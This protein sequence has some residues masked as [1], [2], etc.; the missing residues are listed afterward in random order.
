MV[1]HV[2][3]LLQDLTKEAARDFPLPSL[4]SDVISVELAYVALET[5]VWLH[6]DPLS[7][8]VPS[9]VSVYMYMCMREEEVSNYVC[10]RQPLLL[11]VL[12]H[13]TTLD[14]CSSTP[15]T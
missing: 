6:V 13:I 9:V 1:H 10:F 8:H 7:V 4:C 15:L 14:M 12:P 5:K 2:L 11:L 3:L